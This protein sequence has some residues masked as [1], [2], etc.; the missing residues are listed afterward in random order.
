MD[1]LGETIQVTVLSNG[2]AFVNTDAVR[3]LKEIG[4]VRKGTGLITNYPLSKLQ[5][6]Y[7]KG[8]PQIRDL[9]HYRELVSDPRSPG[10]MFHFTYG[11]SVVME[12]VERGRK[13]VPWYVILDTAIGCHAAFLEE[14]QKSGRLGITSVSG[15]MNEH[16]D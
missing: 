7:L 4:I 13:K 5:H 1:M 15:E 16:R 9:D 8:F 10:P 6:N 2:V 12:Y 3:R 14:M 11:K